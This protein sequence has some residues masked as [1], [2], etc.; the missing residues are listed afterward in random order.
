L[1]L[2]AAAASFAITGNAAQFLRANVLF[3]TWD[4]LLAPINLAVGSIG[5][6]SFALT[7]EAQQFITIRPRPAALIH[8]RL[9]TVTPAA[10]A[11][12]PGS[13]GVFRTPPVLV[14]EPPLTKPSNV[15]AELTPE[16]DTVVIT[17][18][19]G[20]GFEIVTN[21]VAFVKL[22][23]LAATTASFSLTP[24]A[25]ALPKGTAM[26]A[27]SITFSVTPNAVAFGRGLLLGASPASFA[28]TPNDATFRSVRVMMV[29]PSS[30]DLTAL[31]AVLRASRQ[32][33][34][35]PTSYGFTTQPAAL[36]AE[37]RL[38]PVS[39]AIQL[40]PQDASLIYSRTGRVLTASPAA[41]AWTMR[42]TGLVRA[43][44]LYVDAAT[45]AIVAGSAGLSMGEPF[46]APNGD[47][48]ILLMPLDSSV[49]L[50]SLDTGLML[51]GLD[52]SMDLE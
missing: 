29:S 12:T 46:R 1:K 35:V 26:Q 8:G 5:E 37:R 23:R 51:V 14:A 20:F 25:V 24:N 21:A 47:T 27:Q 30:F 13:A 49:D 19:P 34:T 6:E 9:M 15:A 45:F 28:I 11:L 32:L 36:K 17:W 31:D 40:T 48:Y 41:F 10:F 42:Q 2:P 33:A 16:G 44:V 4:D 7:W 39:V 22:H 38:T 50:L 43:R 52:T 3:A 18:E